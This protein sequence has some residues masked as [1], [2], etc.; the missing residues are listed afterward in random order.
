[1]TQI[2]PGDA[3]AYRKLFNFLIKCQSLEYGNQNQFDTP[4]I[5]CMILAIILG[6]LQDKRLNRNMQKIRKVQM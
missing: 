4:D 2:K 6:Y 5:F 1:M 3:A